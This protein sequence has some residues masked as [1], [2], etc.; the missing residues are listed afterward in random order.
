MV[1]VTNIFNPESGLRWLLSETLVVVLG[2]LIALGLNDYWVFR[3]ERALELQYL[4]RIHAD[5]S[6]DIE[7]SDQ[8][9]RDLL[10]RKFQA[11]N[12]IAPIVRGSEPVPDDVELFLRNVS[13]GALG[14]AS[15]T[16][17]VTSTTFEDLKYTGNL[18][19]IRSPDLRRKIARYYEEFD[20]FYIRSRDRKTRYA[21]FVWSALPG[22]LRDDMNLA[23]ME[24][25]GIDRALEL[26]TS[27]EFQNL[28][29]QEYNYAF[30]NQDTDS[31][32]AKRLAKDL[33]T[34]IEQMGGSR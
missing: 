6:A 31:S 29:N 5:V 3:Q 10:E 24:D 8:F 22:E 26:F 27:A 20:E 34:Y 25:F 33:E 30:F 14:G 12:A 11:L 7:F 13:L 32:S 18:R 21:E 16:R 1:Q 4:G 28:L 23:A 9:V 15:S 19:L 2:V 17:W